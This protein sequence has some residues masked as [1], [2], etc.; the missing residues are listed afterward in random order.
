VVASFA[1]SETARTMLLMFAGLANVLMIG[2]LN[3]LQYVM[4]SVLTD[5]RAYDRKHAVGGNYTIVRIFSALLAMTA[6]GS[7][8]ASCHPSTYFIKQAGAAKASD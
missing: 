6:I 3:R 8:V 2:A 5:I 4:Q 7:F 1:L